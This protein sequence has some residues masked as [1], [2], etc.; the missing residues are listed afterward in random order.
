MYLSGPFCVG[1][2]VRIVERRAEG[3]RQLTDND[4]YEAER[5]DQGPFIRHLYRSVINGP[6]CCGQLDVCYRL[7]GRTLGTVCFSGG[8][9]G[10]YRH[11]CSIVLRGYSWPVSYVSIKHNLDRET[12]RA[13]I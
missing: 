13:V 3:Q 11:S 12:N 5:P 6:L 8:G 4:E 9:N 1:G 2:T 7:H 10:N